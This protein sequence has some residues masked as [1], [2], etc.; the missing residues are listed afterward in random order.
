MGKQSWE[1]YK[2]RVPGGAPPMRRDVFPGK[3]ALS[4]SEPRGRRDCEAASLE[5]LGNHG[6]VGR[7]S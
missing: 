1:H 6:L 2:E 5:G 4:E 3:K 7:G